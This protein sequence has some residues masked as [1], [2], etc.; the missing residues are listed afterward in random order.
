MMNRL[1]A[2]VR[3]MRRSGTIT[4]YCRAGTELP[5]GV[6]VCHRWI[7]AS[8]V[9]AIIPGLP[10]V[11]LRAVAMVGRVAVIAGAGI[12]AVIPMVGIVAVIPVVVEGKEG[13]AITPP[14]RW[15]DTSE[16]EHGA[17]MPKAMVKPAAVKSSTAIIGIGHLWL[18]NGDSKEQCC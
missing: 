10:S 8:G 13:I 17:E 1:L 14:K 3:P 4:V 9:G 2:D 7:I 6:A 5:H 15:V 12:V 18:N 11:G 16:P